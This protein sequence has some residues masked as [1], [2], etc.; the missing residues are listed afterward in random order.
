MINDLDV[1]LHGNMLQIIYAMVSILHSLRILTFKVTWNTG[2]ILNIY[3]LWKLNPTVLEIDFRA[4]NFIVLPRRDSNSHLWYTTVLIALPY[5]QII[6]FEFEFEFWS[7]FSNISA[8]SW[9]PVLVVEEAGVPGENYRP[10]ASN[11]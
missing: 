8:M 6:E 5:V 9:R 11:W 7:T 10:W 4:D 2:L 3:I 1:V